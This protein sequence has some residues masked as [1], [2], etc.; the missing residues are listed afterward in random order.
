MDKRKKKEEEAYVRQNLLL[1][2]E[3]T[4]YT[5]LTR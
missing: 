1:I 5:S 3:Q 2:H 4:S